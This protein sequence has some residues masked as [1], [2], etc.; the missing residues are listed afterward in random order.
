MPPKREGDT[1]SS[2]AKSQ[3]LEGHILL[4]A[5]HAD[6][7]HSGTP[8]SRRSSFDPFR[9]PSAPQSESNFDVSKM[10]SYVKSTLFGT[11]FDVP[12]GL[13]DEINKRNCIAFVGSGFTAPLIGDWNKL[14]KMLLEDARN[15]VNDVN[16]KNPEGAAERD[17]QFNFLLEKADKLRT[18]GASSAEYDYFAQEIEDL[19]GEQRFQHLIQGRCKLDDS[20]QISNLMKSRMEA[21]SKIP[22]K[23]IITTNYNNCF[24]GKVA[25]LHGE[26]DETHF[27]DILR[28]ENDFQQGAHDFASNTELLNAHSPSPARCDDP[29]PPSPAPSSGQADR[30]ILTPRPPED[31]PDL[32]YGPPTQSFRHHCQSKPDDLSGMTLGQAREK[33]KMQC[34]VLKIHGCVHHPASIVLSRNAYKRL[35]HETPGYKMFLTTAMATSTMLYIGFSFT[36]DYLNDFRAEVLSM[37][38]PRRSLQHLH[39]P[40]SFAFRST[41]QGKV[42]QPI[43]YGII[44]GRSKQDCSFFRRHEGVEIMT[45]EPQFSSLISPPEDQPDMRCPVWHNG[46]DV[47]LQSIF[48][49][50]HRNYINGQMLSENFFN[51]RRKI[52]TWDVGD[53]KKTANHYLKQCLNHFNNMIR[54]QENSGF[55][56]EALLRLSMYEQA[57]GHSLLESDASSSPLMRPRSVPI[58]LLQSKDCIIAVKDA[59]QL[60]QQ[61][62][63]HAGKVSCVITAFGR[64][65]DLRQELGEDLMYE[66]QNKDKVSVTFVCIVGLHR[67]CP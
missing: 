65:P 20:M 6:R 37:L 23:A 55:R 32:D 3:R 29:S 16:S 45:W 40:K 66:G 15:E 5:D 8:Q 67:L 13:I 11:S 52:I 56:E 62:K 51:S 61:L 44:E 47:Y 58:G 7:S 2:P 50:T 4:D 28:P 59:Q 35:K 22:F 39:E 41:N 64:C 48:R 18:R 60:A 24:V 17:A 21:L 10:T 38:R 19:V 57:T 9:N 54:S 46:L 36:D 43:G 33:Y 53:E 25:T 27:E 49:K 26:L 1:G 42:S 34:P 31:S 63:E 14:L 12:P 30:K